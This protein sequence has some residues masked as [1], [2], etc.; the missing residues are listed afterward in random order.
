MI[1]PSGKKLITFLEFVQNQS[2]IGLKDLE[3]ESPGLTK[4][5][6]SLLCDSNS[7]SILLKS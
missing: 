5:K 1:F 4:I 6:G 2:A 3:E 7:N